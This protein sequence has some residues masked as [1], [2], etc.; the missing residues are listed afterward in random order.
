MRGGWYSSA[1]CALIL[2]GLLAWT[3]FPH[4]HSCTPMV[5]LGHIR[6]DC[7]ALTCP[8]P[9][10]PRSLQSRKGSQHLSPLLFRLAFPPSLPVPRAPP[11]VPWWGLSA[12][13]CCQD[14]KKPLCHL[15]TNL[16]RI[17]LHAHKFLRSVASP[18]RSK[19]SLSTQPPMASACQVPSRPNPSLRSLSAAMQTKNGSSHPD[20]HMNDVEAEAMLTNSHP[21]LPP[22]PS[23]PPTWPLTCHPFRVC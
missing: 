18:S 1:V 3:L 23:T 12:G 13:Q 9:E 20:V 6:A 11:F 15:C 22:P 8:A 16:S 14:A 17:G 10:P 19:L 21:K 4:Q 2:S 7:V 5:Q